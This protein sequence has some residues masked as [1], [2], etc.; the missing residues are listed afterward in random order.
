MMKRIFT[1]VPVV[2][3]LILGLGFLG[4]LGLGDA[5]IVPTAQ[6][7]AACSLA[8]LRGGYGYTATAITPGVGENDAV[9]VFPSMGQET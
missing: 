8:T 6:A 5:G 9:G 1:S 2:S 4:N 3:L 7:A